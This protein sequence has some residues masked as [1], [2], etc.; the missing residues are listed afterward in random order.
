MAHMFSPQ[1]EGPEAIS[2]QNP[3]AGP[4]INNRNAQFVLVGL[5]VGVQ[6]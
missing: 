3:L 4:E 5:N 6:R 1:G 2:G